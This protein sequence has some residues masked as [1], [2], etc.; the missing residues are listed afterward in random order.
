[1]RYPTRHIVQGVLVALVLAM[2]FGGLAL[3]AFVPQ[4]PST[5]PNE[6]TAAVSITPQPTVAIAAVTSTPAP[7]AT[8]PPAPTPHPCEP[9]PI[10]WQDVSE[11]DPKTWV[12]PA[13][14]EVCIP[15]DWTLA[16]WR[17]DIPMV[18]GTDHRPW[19]LIAG[20]PITSPPGTAT[21]SEITHLLLDYDEWLIGVREALETLDYS[22]IA[23]LTTGRFDVVARD[24]ME[25]LQAEHRTRPFE[26]TELQYRDEVLVVD[27][28]G[29]TATVFLWRRGYRA[30]YRYL[31]TGGLRNPDDHIVDAGAW[32]QRWERHP[33]LT[34]NR[35]LL[36]YSLPLSFFNDPREVGLPHVPA[37]EPLMVYHDFYFAILKREYEVSGW[38]PWW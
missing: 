3:W 5:N 14:P 25:G 28:R 38:T 31:D 30:H 33:D 27:M 23:D 37:F 35:W 19:I 36:E 24:A 34:Q 1:M 17:S 16:T 20:K 2:V 4:S 11:I 13:L 21:L 8:L 22:P 12:A 26:A 29:L 9:D 10:E 32:M 7:T 15:D 18:G 6:P